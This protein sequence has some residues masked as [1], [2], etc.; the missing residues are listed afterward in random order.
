MSQ[1]ATIT[2]ITTPHVSDT[3][4]QHYTTHAAT[5]GKPY[6]KIEIKRHLRARMIFRG[7]LFRPKRS[8]NMEYV[9]D[10]ENQTNTAIFPKEM[11]H[12]IVYSGENVR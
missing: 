10:S 3:E 8:I 6:S 7:E 5:W 11:P 1:S 2:T 9:E 12:H 4:S